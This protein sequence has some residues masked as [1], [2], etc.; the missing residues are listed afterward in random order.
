MERI[1]KIKRILT[2]GFNYVTPIL[3][4]HLGTQ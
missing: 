1:R 4:I 3:E 2:L